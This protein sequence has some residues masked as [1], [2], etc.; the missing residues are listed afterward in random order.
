MKTLI[1]ALLTCSLFQSTMAADTP[2]A[3]LLWDSWYTVTLT[4]QVPYGY[5][6]DRVEKKNGKIAFKN[7]FWKK[8]EGFINEEK[9][10]V[11]AED[12][13]ELKPVL[14]NFQSTYR[15]TKIDIDGNVKDKNLVVKARKDGKDLKPIT[16]NLT[17]GTYFSSLFP[18][19]VGK[20]IDTLKE[21]KLVS[22]T[23]ILEDN[24]DKGY[25]P[26]SGQLRLEKADDFATQNKAKKIAVEY[27][28]RKST[29]YLG[30]NGE[31]LK[32]IMQ[33]QNAV[34]EKVTEAVARKFLIQNDGL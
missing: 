4:G 8:E 30:A 15:N 26:V 28:D 14:F 5:Y 3:N 9:L 16:R 13:Q 12:T 25:A 33:D 29:W 21:G 11:F 10:V 20:R 7:E 27:Q 2:K 22:F 24:L 31:T 17:A 34:V 1:F 32:M 6:H 23:T 18:V 19:W